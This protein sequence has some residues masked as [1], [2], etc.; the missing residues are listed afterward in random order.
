MKRNQKSTHSFLAPVGLALAAALLLACSR[1][2]H[3]QDNDEESRVPNQVSRLQV[4]D[5]Q[6]IDESARLVAIEVTS[7]GYSPSRV[8]AKAG[9][10]ITLVFTRTEPTEC[11]SVVTVAGNDQRIYLPMNKAVEVPIQ[12][13]P[14]GELPFA[15][16]MNMMR[17]VVSAGGGND[18]EDGKVPHADHSP[19][20]G[21]I[22]LM[23][24]NLHFEVVIVPKT[25]RHEIYFS[26]EVRNALPASAVQKVTI[27]VHRIGGSPKTLV[28]K[29]STANT[30][31]LAMGA[32]IDDPQAFSRIAYTYQGKPYEIDVPM[33]LP[34]G[35]KS[36]GGIV[37]KTFG[38]QMGKA[39]TKK[40]RN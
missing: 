13:P 9:E 28:T 3:I 36:H 30:F 24:E 4:T 38:G 27:S 21:G 5:R 33:P 2:G 35:A 18:T 10:K 15:C 37:Q 31:W 6:A 39:R 22:V 1:E 17:G 8:R 7:A 34:H 25:G 26:D 16:G 19:R 12:V 11:G 23:D 14:S 29:A 20:H 40:A 32:P